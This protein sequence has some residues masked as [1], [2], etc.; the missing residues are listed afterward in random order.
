LQPP[1][2]PAPQVVFVTK[3]VPPR[4]RGGAWKVAYAD[5][6][7]ALLALFIVLWMMN[8]SVQVKES[9]SGYFRDPRGYT[10]KLGAGPGSPAE[11]LR[12]THKS[13]AEIQ[14]Q[15]EEALRRA[16]DLEKL[17]NHVRMSVTGEGLRIDMM[18]TEQGM[19]FETGS[20][21]P[22]GAG[23]KLLSILGG[24]IGRMPN[25][26]V[27]EGHTDARP[28]RN[29]ASS[30]GYSNW[31]LSADRANAARRLLSSYGVRDSQVV[32]IRG[33][34]SQMPLNAKDPNDT[35]NRRISVVVRFGPG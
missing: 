19:F 26:V 4:R 8:S 30:S 15:I 17:R 16:P 24:E 9:I 20:P 12:I 13:A 11:G 27:I 23:Q 18:E 7:T 28:F 21:N 2:A 22:T 31:E 10:R 29:T 33:Y 6:V 34:A 25:A 1:P 14:K 32:E 5:F 3:R 35:R